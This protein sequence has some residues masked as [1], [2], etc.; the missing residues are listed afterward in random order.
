MKKSLNSCVPM[1]L[2]EDSNSDEFIGSDTPESRRSN[3]LAP[4]EAI[5]ANPIVI[6][7][8]LD[9]VMTPDAAPAIEGNVELMAAKIIGAIKTPKQPPDINR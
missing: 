1:L 2:I 9:V 6:P 3:L 5:A 7:R 8:N 4:H